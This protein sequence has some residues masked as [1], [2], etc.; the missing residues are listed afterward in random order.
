TSSDAFTRMAGGRKADISRDAGGAISMF[1]G[2]INGRNIELVP[3]QRVVQAWRAAGWP[4]GIYSMVHF[5]LLPEGKGA[6]LVFDQAGHPEGAQA[7]LEGGWRQ[8]YWQPMKEALAG[9]S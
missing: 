2:D 5:E 9:K 4:V 1:G 7:M 6:R 3:G 8:M